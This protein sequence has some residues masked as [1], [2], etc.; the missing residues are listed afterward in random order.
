MSDVVISEEAL[1]DLRRKAEAYDKIVANN[2]RAGKASTSK[3]TAEERRA[4]AKKAAASRW[5]KRD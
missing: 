3:L 4:R 5:K 1:L 2:S